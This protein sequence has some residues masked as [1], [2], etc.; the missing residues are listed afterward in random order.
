M[1]KVLV[2]DTSILV[3]WLKV[4]GLEEAGPK[5]DLWDHG[6]VEKLINEYKDAIYVL[7]L[8]TII[9]A[10]NLI[11]K[12]SKDQR[13]QFAQ[14][15]SDIIKLSC[16]GQSPWAVFSDQSLL[17]EP[18]HLIKLADSWPALT[19]GNRCHSMG[20]ATIKTVAEHYA[21]MGFPVDIVTADFGLKQ[22]QPTSRA[23]PV[24]RR[25]S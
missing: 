22:F 9:E 24:P 5:H 7:P 11:C 21:S 25:K 1:D 3:V 18:E 20:D 6:R 13:Q 23:T 12:I 2:F 19:E 10:G 15:L 17:W 4:P 14:K 16:E 8:A